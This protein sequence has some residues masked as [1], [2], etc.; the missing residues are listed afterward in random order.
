MSASPVLVKRLSL[1]GFLVALLGAVGVLTVCCQLALA[2][3]T[4]RACGTSYGAGVFAG[5]SASDMS[6]TAR[7]PVVSI[8]QGGLA[9]SNTSGTSARGDTAR[10]QADAPPGL[11]IV[12]A[13]VPSMIAYNMNSPKAAF[14][15]GFY[16]QGGGSQVTSGQSAALVGGFASPY[17]GFQVICGLNQCPYAPAGDLQVNDIALSVRETTGPSFVAPT[18][19]WQAAGWVHGSWPFF[20]WGNSPSGLCSLSATLNG[21]LINETTS[22]QDV[23]TWHQCAAPP[24]AQPVD[25]SRYGQGALPLTLSAGDAAGVPAS[26]TK[27]VYVDNQQPT[28]SLSG[29]SDAPS[30]AGTQYVTATAS[31]GPSGVA[32]ISCS[33]DGAPAQWYPSSTAQVPVSGVGEHQAQCNSE[34][35]A[36]DG[37]EVHGTSALGSFSIKIGVP[38]ISAI[39]F[40]R[41]VD[42]LRCHRVHEQIKVPARW[43]KVRRHHK[44]VRVHRR[45][46]RKTVKVTRCHARTVRKRITVRVIVRRHG[47]KVRVKRHKIV[48]VILLPR[49][50]SRATRRVPYGRPTTVSGWLGTTAGTALP[51]QSVSVMTAPDNGQGQFSTAAVVSTAANGSWTATLPAGPSRLV[52]A[53]YGGGSTTEAA[54]SAQV[55]V[56]VPAKVKLLRIFPKQIPW[57]GSVRITGQLEGG[58]LPAGGALVRLRIG[59]GKAYTTYGV[60]THVTG[61]GRFSTAYTFG[62]G[63]PSVRHSYWFSFASLPMGSYPYAPAASRRGYVLLGG[64]PQIPPPRPHRRATRHDHNHRRHQRS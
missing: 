48:R 1:R 52:E 50:V 63:D 16:W 11:Q 49:V 7:C 36:V 59:S 28:V 34:N 2:N 20:T 14:G 25:T 53:V 42:Q 33:V 5:S 58:Y 38:T 57:G 32:G 9:V 22:S 4:V 56:T 51:G 24:I 37:N 35:N 46:H 54:A 60:Q 12:G 30:T 40:S 3:E 13:G 61:T 18:G 29:P 31:A 19:L 43:A 64:H 27:T 44:L 23:S 45:A 21:V 55:R 10:F 62:A 41:I 47:K 8:S 15:G 39:A 6:A 17:F 26:T